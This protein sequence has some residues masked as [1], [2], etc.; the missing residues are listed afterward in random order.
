MTKF[1]EK[2]K[3]FLFGK[4]ISATFFCFWISITVQTF[5]K[6]LMNRNQGKLVTDVQAHMDK[7]E[8]IEIG[9]PPPGIQ[10]ISF[11]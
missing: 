10:N 3:R 2:S 4:Y 7:H 8:I 1:Y 9:A 11:N 5:R 6:K